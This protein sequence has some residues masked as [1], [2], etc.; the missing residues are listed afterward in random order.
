MSQAP[1]ISVIVPVYNTEKYLRKCLDS[2]CGQTYRNLEII[3]VNDGSPDNSATILEE[4]AAR[5]ER[6]KVLTQANAGLAAARNAGLAFASGE[7]VTGVDSDDYL[8]LDAYEYAINAAT[9]DVDIVC[10]GTRLVWKG[11]KYNEAYEKSKGT[12]GR[13]NDAAKYIDPRKD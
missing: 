13:F 11:V 9:P 5:D 7:W 8:E 2:I 4:Y 1:L 3:C 6:I 10:F 12:Y